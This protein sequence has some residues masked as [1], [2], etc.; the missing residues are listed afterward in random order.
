MSRKV[1]YKYELIQ[2]ISSEWWVKQ[3]KILTEI[4]SYCV[5]SP[6]YDSRFNCYE[7]IEQQE[8]ENEQ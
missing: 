4:C 1:D 5:C 6:S 3:T 8:K 2:N 7:W